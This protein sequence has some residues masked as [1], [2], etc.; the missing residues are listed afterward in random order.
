MFLSLMISDGIT[1]GESLL[2]IFLG[3]VIGFIIT[4]IIAFV[5]DYIGKNK[6]NNTKDSK[7][8]KIKEKDYN[9]DDGESGLP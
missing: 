2:G 4:G 1:E 9:V 3:L 8:E 6:K 7:I 5:S